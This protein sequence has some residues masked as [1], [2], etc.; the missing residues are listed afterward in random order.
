MK[1]CNHCMACVGGICRA[2]KCCGSISGIVDGHGKLTA[3]MA[4]E[5]YRIACDALRP[6]GGNDS[7]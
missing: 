6:E 2:E 7:Q 4:E 1:D 3:E 5:A